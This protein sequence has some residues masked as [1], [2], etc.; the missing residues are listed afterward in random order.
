MF[1]K[2][3]SQNHVS[4]LSNGG[5]DY[6]VIVKSNLT[7]I[8]NKVEMS[9]QSFVVLLLTHILG[10]QDVIVFRDL[11]FTLFHKIVCWHRILGILL[12]L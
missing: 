11:L 12:H 6:K 9:S 3:F 1:L 4:R 10:F 5:A 2:S 7:M 8:C